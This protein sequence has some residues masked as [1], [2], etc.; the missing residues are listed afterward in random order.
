MCIK[1]ILLKRKQKKAA[2]SI[3]NAHDSIFGRKIQKISPELKIIICGLIFTFVGV[4]SAWII[5]I[6]DCNINQH[7]KQYESSTPKSQ[8]QPNQKQPEQRQ[9]NTQSAV[10]V[11]KKNDTLPH[12]KQTTK[13]KSATKA[14]NVSN[15]S[16]APKQK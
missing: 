7:P 8:T 16:Q 4:I 2:K 1:N 6:L 15:S 12:S 5:F 13:H 9:Y 14:K 11:Q 10:S 3:I